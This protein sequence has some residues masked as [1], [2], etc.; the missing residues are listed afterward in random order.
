MKEDGEQRNKDTEG[1]VQR[2]SPK[3]KSNLE[4]YTKMRIM[5]A[6]NYLLFMSMKFLPIMLEWLLFLVMRADA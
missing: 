5:S 2:G 1:E 3:E 4:L 6:E